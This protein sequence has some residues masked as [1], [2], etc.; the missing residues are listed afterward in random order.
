MGRTAASIIAVALLTAACASP[1]SD[2]PE[3]RSSAEPGRSTPRTLPSTV[4]AP[5]AT[6]LIPDPWTG[7]PTPN[8]VSTEAVAEALPVS[9]ALAAGTYA[10]ANPYTDRDP[11]RTCDETCSHYRQV[12]FTLPEGWAVS[13]GLV[14]KNLGQP[15]EMAFSFWT[16]D[17]VYAD[18]CHWED[19]ELTDLDLGRHEHQPDGALVVKS[20][21]QGGLLNQ[22]GRASAEMTQ[23]TQ[24]GRAILRIELAISA[25]LDLA[26][27]DRGEFRAWTEWDV[28]DGANSRHAPGQIDVVYMIDV[29]LRPLVIDASHLPST[30]AEDLAELEA[31]LASMRWDY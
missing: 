24:S 4:A 6:R 18:G 17:Q 9:G 8:P 20:G 10:F 5:S 2:P 15:T 3:P 26:A 21:G 30:S 13:D 11:I 25:D 31:V 16:V 22:A 28:A 23:F 7:G 14:S 29:D 12:V 27:C 1:P 19:S